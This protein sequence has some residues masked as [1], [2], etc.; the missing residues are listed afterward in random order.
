MLPAP[1]DPRRATRVTVDDRLWYWLYLPIARGV[2]LADARWSTVLQQGRI[3][4]Y[5][6]YSFVTLLALLFFV[7]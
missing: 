2:E 7:R 6:L 1:F 5:L 3:S 4:V